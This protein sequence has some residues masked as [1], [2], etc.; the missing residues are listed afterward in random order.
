MVTSPKG[1]SS[2]VGTG[3]FLGGKYS[4]DNVIAFGG[5]S[6]VDVSCIRSSD[7]IWAQPNADMTQLERTQQQASARDPSHYSGTK[8]LSHFTIASFSDEVILSKTT[9]LG[10]SLGDSNN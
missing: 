10:I 1:L 7:H 2:K 3:A 9:K 4:V 8:N 5:I 6:E